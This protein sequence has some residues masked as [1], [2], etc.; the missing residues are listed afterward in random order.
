M[1]N[2]MTCVDVRVDVCAPIP[3]STVPITLGLSRETQDS[4]QSQSRSKLLI[5]RTKSFNV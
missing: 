1:A 5:E 2:V 3:Q 4:G